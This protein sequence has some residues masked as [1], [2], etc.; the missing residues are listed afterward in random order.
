MEAG[1]KITN[2]T[3]V[4]KTPASYTEL[5][6]FQTGS[7]VIGYGGS[8]VY[9]AAVVIDESA[10]F[11]MRG[12]EISNTNYRGV[13]LGLSN[14]A[15]TFIME[16]GVI[17]TNGKSPVTYD[18]KE[19]YQSGGGVFTVYLSSQQVSTFTMNG[20]EIS[21]N[22][23]SSAPGSGIY[24]QIVTSSKFLVNGTIKNNSIAT[25]QI[26]TVQQ[27]RI[28]I[29][30][31]LVP[32]LQGSTIGIDL[33][34]SDAFGLIEWLDNKTALTGSGVTINGDIVA[35]FTPVK[36][37][38]MGNSTAPVTDVSDTYRYMINNTGKV[39]EV[40]AE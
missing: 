23:H 34:A 1:A 3:L 15:S 4:V 12:G 10:R 38:M 17:K 14:T 18:G 21:D 7:D 32:N 11:T 25:R 19:Y 28:R 36:C 27:G 6:S 16:G 8:F 24:S 40:P 29:G 26:S 20:G 30:A 37:Y 5:A 2:N 35:H 33:C 22:G 9:I 13:F 31:D 39:V